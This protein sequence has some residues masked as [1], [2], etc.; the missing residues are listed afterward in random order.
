MSKKLKSWFKYKVK[1]KA[2]TARLNGQAMYMN[3]FS[4][5]MQQKQVKTVKHKYEK[6]KYG[7]MYQ[8]QAECK[9]EYMENGMSSASIT[10]QPN[11]NV[12]PT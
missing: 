4:T 12:R 7:A 10:F 11:L 1:V 2:K 6:H 3:K 9:T 8:L 5:H